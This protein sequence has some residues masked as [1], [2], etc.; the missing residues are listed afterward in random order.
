MLLVTNW[1]TSKGTTC[2]LR[3]AR[4]GACE[5][6]TIVRILSNPINHILRGP[7]GGF[8][9]LGL[10]LRLWRHTPRP[11]PQPSRLPMP[12][13]LLLPK[14]RKQAASRHERRPVLVTW[15]KTEIAVYSTREAD[16]VA[17]ASWTQFT[18]NFLYSVWLLNL[19][20]PK[21]SWRTLSE[22][23]TLRKLEYQC[24]VP[25]GPYTKPPC[26]RRTSKPIGRSLL[27][28]WNWMTPLPRF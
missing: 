27:P 7:T 26:T 21:S 19:R 6:H 12:P 17:K 24:T 20:A 23:Y 10:V 3:G 4:L 16:I 11:A 14:A 18:C 25:G 2:H 1:G 13:T 9:C 28:P 5:N 22:L 15:H 8:L